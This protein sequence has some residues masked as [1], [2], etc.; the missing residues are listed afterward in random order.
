MTTIRDAEEILKKEYHRDNFLYLTKEVLLPDFVNDKHEVRFK[1]SIFNRVTQLGESH[2][3]DVVVYEVILEAGVQNRR[4]AITQEMFRI[5]RG[6][7]INNALVAFSNSDGNNYSISLL[8]SKYDSDGKLKT[9]NP[10]R[11]SYSLGYGTK[12]K[13][14][15]L[16]LIEKGKAN[17]LDDL[18]ERFSVKVV[19]KQFYNEIALHF[20]ELVGGERDDKKYRRQLKLHGV[21]EQNK[22]T[23]FTVRLIGRIIFCW[24]LKEKK[25]TD[26]IS[27]IPN[28]IL[29]F[30]AV[31]QNESYYHNILEPLFFELLNTNQA[32]RKDKF[33]KDDIYKQVP[34]L[35]GG[36]FNPHADDQYI[37]SSATESGKFGLVT[38]PDKWFENFFEVLELYNFTVDENTVYDVELSIDPEMLGR[39]FESLLAEQINPETKE[40]AKKS[41]GSFYTPRDIVDYMVDNS[42]YEYL[43]E[44]T[45][46]D[47][48]KLKAAISYVKEDDECIDFSDNEKKKIIDA[49]YTI[50]ILDPACGSGA[51]PIGMLQK[52]IYILQ[53][54][55]SEAKLWF[56][57]AMENV[58]IFLKKELEKKFNAGS[59]D[60]IRKL[61]VI[62]N[63]IF[64]VD[65]Q[66]IAIEIARLRC[67]LSL[68][69]EEKVEDGEENRG[70]KPLPNLD[71]KFVIADTL[72]V[73]SEDLHEDRELIEKLKKVRGE[74]FNANDDKRNELRSEFY[75]IQEKMSQD[76]DY[77]TKSYRYQSL[78]H[79][80][81]FKNDST[82]WFDSELM[83]GVKMFDIVIGNPPYL[84][85]GRIP[86]KLIEKYKKSHYYQGK[87]DLWYMFAC[88]GIDF[89][90]NNGLLCFIAKNNWRTNAGAKKLRNKVVIESQIK[91][92]VDFGSFMIFEDADIQT[93]VMLFSKNSV[94]DNYNFDYRKL[95]RE[96][97]FTDVLDLLNKKSNNKAL[98]LFPEIVRNDL[99]N[100]ILTFSS[101]NDN[102]ILDN[103]FK[104]GIR[105][106]EN[107]IAQGIV[108]PQDFLNRENQEILG[109]KFIIGEGIF[110]LTK[111]EKDNLR[112]S[113]DELKLIKPYYTTEQ[114]HRY[115]SNPKNKLWIIYT[116]S[117]FKNPNSMNNY[118]N[119]KK[120]LDKFAKVITS[121][122]KP[123]GLHRTRK[124]QFFKG[125]K[126]IVQR[127]CA[128]Q[129][130][131]SYS[132]FDCYVS[133]TFFVIKASSFNLKY[134]VG[135]LNSKLIAF[136]LRNKGKM[137][138]GNYQVDK[139]PLLQIPIFDATPKQQ[140]II[141]ILVDYILFLKQTQNDGIIPMY[142]ENIIDAC[143]YELYFPEE[144]HI[145]KKEVITY[146]HDMKS[147]NDSMNNEQKLSI[148]NSEF[149]R[150]YDTYHPVRNNVE[151]IENI[152]ILRTIK[153]SSKQ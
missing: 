28:D 53:E 24:F 16:F 26:G 103:M 119:L 68:I 4:I 33:R 97:I 128:G 100:S 80:E 46:I 32:Q 147:I 106:E 130:S 40:V 152:E 114:I 88:D 145:A 76:K 63:S 58:E 138:G 129:P 57:K 21:E 60:Y 101:D 131:F 2:A 51:F 69:I 85:E 74:Y 115:Y 56:D 122:N 86:K 49:L 22:Y 127:K 66:S 64:G 95:V 139:E 54:I 92:F 55:D 42:L 149:E 11:Y 113:K 71:F 30:S 148:I 34:Y 143:V 125:E 99:K 118:P 151:T 117:S 112:L 150:L 65:N 78:S 108:F 27:L 135:L 15:Y 31:K 81:P 18:I 38:I 96:S 102:K 94:I 7:R 121:S 3:C 25:S 153:E 50:A 116:D 136:W 142:Y 23:E 1:N 43:Y 90:K 84:Q 79:W 93:M 105:L 29:S 134:L 45:N 140:Q 19:N 111:D 72:L 123:Y 36:L 70:I 83:F 62:Q 77:K 37:Y 52:I 109:D 87:M 20:T 17:S 126:I 141:R 59:L 133:A 91:Q 9:S 41:S 39:I 144:V 120:H 67:F 8:T 82:Q 107:E 6:H 5:L 104:K 10:R 47:G 137:Q 14:A 61:S 98:Y 73:L 124:E 75:K 48:D 35:N 44:K 132:D 110:G 89:L 12:T 146:L 13:T